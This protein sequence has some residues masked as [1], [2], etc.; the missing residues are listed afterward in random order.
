MERTRHAVMTLA[1][2]LDDVKVSDLQDHLQST[3]SSALS[4]DVKR[5]SLQLL[6]QSFTA[7]S[8]LTGD[9]TF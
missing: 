8:H 1:N 6:V 7:P 4:L 2:V 9:P 3:L 5:L